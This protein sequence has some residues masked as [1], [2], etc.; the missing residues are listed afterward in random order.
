MQQKQ[1]FA[2]ILSAPTPTVAAEQISSSPN[3]K[4]ARDLLGR[5][6]LITFTNNSAA[7]TD[8]GM[9]VARDEGISDE[10]GQLTDMGQQLSGGNSDQA[11]LNNMGMPEEEPPLG[12]VPAEGG[13]E[14]LGS[15]PMESFSVL[16]ELMRL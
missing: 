6:G 9:A 1:V 15:P 2:A 8:M 4:S 12:G 5:L 14:D 10:G 11:P 13:D 7:L 3:L 16:R